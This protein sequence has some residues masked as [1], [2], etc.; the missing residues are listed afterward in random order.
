MPVP[1]NSHEL[2]VHELDVLV[3]HF[4]DLIDCISQQQLVFPTPSDLVIGFLC[5]ILVVLLT[6]DSCLFLYDLLK[7]GCGG[8]K[9]V[10]FLTERVH[11]EEGKPLL[12]RPPKVP[13]LIPNSGLCIPLG[14]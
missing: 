2:V 6:R 9:E 12:G 1:I 3:R 4:A 14:S 5:F 7:M 8:S 11:G 13:L 10:D